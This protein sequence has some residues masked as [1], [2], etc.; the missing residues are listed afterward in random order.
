MNKLMIKTGTYSI[1]HMAVAIMVAYVISGSWAIA[2][3][4]GFIEPIV[5]T[6]FYNFH[7]RAWSFFGKKEVLPAE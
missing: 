4:I 7:E 1:M 5:Q 2:L 3:G 6:I